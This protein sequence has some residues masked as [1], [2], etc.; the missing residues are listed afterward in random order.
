MTA[1]RF[2]RRWQASPRPPGS[3]PPSCW[4]V[5]VLIRTYVDYNKSNIF[6]KK[7]KLK[8][9]YHTNLHLNSSPH[10]DTKEG[11]YN[12]K[13]ILHSIKAILPFFPKTADKINMNNNKK[14]EIY[15]RLV[16][17]NRVMTGDVAQSRETASH[18]QMIIGLFGCQITFRYCP[19]L[20]KEFIFNFFFFYV[21]SF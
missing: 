6:L 16:E 3:R 19:R 11:H 15:Y 12:N 18:G 2:Y 4:Y 10:I 5:G 21:Y 9:P 1:E 8:Q 20:K 7:K 17:A 14:R 13:T